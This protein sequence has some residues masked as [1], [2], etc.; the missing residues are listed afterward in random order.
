MITEIV[1]HGSP[2]HLD[3]LVA[4][5]LL[6]QHGEEKLPG[7]NTAQFRCLTAQDNVEELAQREDTVLLGLGA[8]FRD[9]GNK[10]RIVDEH[11][12]TGDQTQKNE[13]AATLAAKF[14]G[15]DQEFRWRK[16]LRA[17]LHTDKNPP[18]LALDLS[19][20]VMEFQLQGW[21]LHAVLQY[22]EMTLNAHLKKA[23]QFAATS[24]LPMRQVELQLNGKQ[25]WI[26]VIE[27]DDPKAP[28]FARFL[29][30]AVVVVK[31]PSGHIQILPTS[32]LRLD[33]RDVVRVLRSREEWARGNKLDIP[34]KQIE[35][36]GA[37]KDYPTWFFH[38]ETNNI[39]NGGRS[40]PDI[41]A[42][43]I[44]LDTIVETVKMCL[45]GGFE[46]SRQ[47]RCR[48]GICTSTLKNQCRWYNFALLRCRAIQVKMH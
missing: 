21:G 43:K 48:E 22:T 41:P 39:L 5:L 9:E 29:G 35:Q 30:A 33:M 28:A 18:N 37:L 40:R 27:G 31:N 19:V 16:I 20:T 11:V 15:L 38:K 26:T 1:T 44:P 34:W 6:Q 4:V 12:V 17:V 13:C 36:E 3:E 42:T 7:V 10:H 2:A 47:E 46:P 14:L 8:A 45:E 25:Q 23:D 32:H 24:L